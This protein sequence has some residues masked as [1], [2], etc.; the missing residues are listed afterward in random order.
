MSTRCPGG[1]INPEL[2]V[3]WEIT[4]SSY[5]KYGV[6]GQILLMHEH[7]SLNPQEGQ[8]LPTKRDPRCAPRDNSY[9]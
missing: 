3:L 7:L 2:P 4:I 8:G 9:L 1:I 6:S 5:K